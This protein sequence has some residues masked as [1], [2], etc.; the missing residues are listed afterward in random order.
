MDAPLLPWPDRLSREERKLAKQRE[1]DFHAS[2]KSRARDA[3]WR[4]AAGEI[5]RRE[6]DW[7][8]CNLPSLAWGRGAWARLTVKP[9]ALDPLF[10]EIVGL[11]ENNALPLSFRANGAWVLRPEWHVGAIATQETAVEK[12]ADQMLDWSNRQ[13]DIDGWSIRRMLDGLGPSDGL[14][15]QNRT[16][17]ICLHLLEGNF[18]EAELLCRQA[19]DQ[20]PLEADGGGFTTGHGDGTRSTFNQQALAW[21]AKERRTT[22]TLT[23]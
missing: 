19:G 23:P 8:V 12:L 14:K 11:S 4:Y 21:I 7:F 3:G 2:L 16:L 18:D 22:M 15:Y 10:W 13:I 9:M 1:R 6:G 20:S 5:F 17:A